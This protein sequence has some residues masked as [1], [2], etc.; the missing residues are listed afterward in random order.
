MSVVN[1]T[2]DLI[3]ILSVDLLK[4]EKATVADLR[5][6]S[7][8]TNIG[9]GWH[10]LLDLAW[11]VR[12]AGL[13]PGDHA[14]DAGAGLGILQWYLSERAIDVLSVDRMPRDAMPVRLRVRYDVRG[15]RPNDLLGIGSA[16]WRETTGPASLRHHVREPIRVL[17]ALGRRLLRRV[18]GTVTIM[19][20]DL[21][22]LSLLEDS[23]FDAI[24]SV[25]SLEHNDPGDLEQVVQE[26]LR[27]LRPGGRLVATLGAARDA[28][29]FHKPS[30][31]WCYTEASLRRSFGLSSAAP[32]NYG[33]Y[34][35]LFGELRDCAEL[36]DNLAPAYFKSGD[37]GMPWGT[38][39]PQY[40]SVGLVKVKPQ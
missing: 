5:R 31:G 6:V 23:S 38:W 9:F 32:S 2:D 35:R 13:K 28:D 21:R 7:R 15:Y 27:V 29:W 3:E 11:V 8:T 24:V 37:N 30:R 25:S 26:L 4:S 39:D 16:L 20:Q 12:H 14:L 19:N 36:R 17:E 18:P 10:Y 40:Q 22:D 33:E 34:D 1:G